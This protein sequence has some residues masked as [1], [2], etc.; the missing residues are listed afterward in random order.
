[1][2]SSIGNG[3][4]NLDIDRDFTSRIDTTATETR[5]IKTEA[6][7]RETLLGLVSLMDS[8]VHSIRVS[9]MD[10]RVHS[11]LNIVA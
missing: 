11:T 1:M 7:T 3:R 8:R 5:L 2:T 9:L 4:L 6:L 10:S